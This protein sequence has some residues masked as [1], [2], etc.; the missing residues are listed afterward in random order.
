MSRDKG[1]QTTTTTSAPPAYIA[2]FLRDAA[3]SAFSQFQ[4]GG[5]PIIGFGQDTQRALNMAR[6]RAIAGSPIT[7]AANNFTLD[8]LNGS[9]MGQNPGAAATNPFAFENNENPFLREMFGQGAQAI[10]NQVQSDFGR[11]GRNVRGADAAGVAAGRLG[12]FASQ[13]FGGAFE[14]EANRRFNAAEANLGRQFQAFENERQR[15]Q[16]LVPLAPLLAQQD[17]AD[18][19]QLANVGAIEDELQQARANAPSQ[20]L[21]QLIGQLASLSGGFGTTTSQVPYERNRLAGALGGA[22]AGSIFGP[23]GMLGGAILGAL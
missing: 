12:D 22:T 9:F 1:T 21:N 19:S 11:A 5:T 6:D 16:D 2:P 20:N 23:F 7:N 17:F 10:T 4:G 3:Q 8:T 13:L 15:Q 18:I 14:N